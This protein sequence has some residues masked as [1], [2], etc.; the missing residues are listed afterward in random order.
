MKKLWAIALF[1][2]I[3]GSANAASSEERAGEPTGTQ[4][5]QSVCIEIVSCGTKN[6]KRK[7]YPTPCEARNDGATK[8]TPKTSATCEDEAK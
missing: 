7:E 4:M 2:G 6:G 8:I 1:S 3:I 5:Q